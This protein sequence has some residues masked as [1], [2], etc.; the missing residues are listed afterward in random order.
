VA[1]RVQEV[2]T[3]R[4]ASI[5]GPRRV[6]LACSDAQ[7]RLENAVGG[8]RRSRGNRT[9]KLFAMMARVREGSNKGQDHEERTRL[10]TSK[11][12]YL[13]SC[14]KPARPMP[15]ITRGQRRKKRR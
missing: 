1:D 7:F 12:R 14:K 6:R 2:R 5:M 9:G 13:R 15:L 4:D 10:V 8:I 11:K 3:L